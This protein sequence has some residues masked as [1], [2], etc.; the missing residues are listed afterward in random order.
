MADCIEDQP[1]GYA[2][3]PNCA[4]LEPH[5]GTA[6]GAALLDPLGQF[7]SELAGRWRKAAHMVV[8][9]WKQGVGWA[10]ALRFGEA[11]WATVAELAGVKPPSTATIECVRRLV[12]H[13]P[14]PLEL[15]SQSG[16]KQPRSKGKGSRR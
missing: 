7:D 16:T 6:P 13:M 8:V 15:E 11:D 3:C 14:D 10:D 2:G 1:C 12:L 9:L 4:H 5:V